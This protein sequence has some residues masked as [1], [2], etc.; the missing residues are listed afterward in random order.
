MIVFLWLEWATGRVGEEASPLV[1]SLGGLTPGKAPSLIFARFVSPDSHHSGA[2][3]L[4]HLSLRQLPAVLAWFPPWPLLLVFSQ[5]CFYYQHC[6]V[7]LC[8]GKGEPGRQRVWQWR[9]EGLRGPCC[10]YPWV[11]NHR[12]TGTE[13][14][15]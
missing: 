8:L 4:C 5:E 7:S 3:E 14:S 1:W 9:P 2:A 13:N 12:Q 10:L 15:G 6:W 11:Q